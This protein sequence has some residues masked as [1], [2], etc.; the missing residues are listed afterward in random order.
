MSYLIFFPLSH[1]VSTYFHKFA[2]WKKQEEV[3]EVL[4]MGQVINDIVKQL[5]L[6]DVLIKLNVIP[7]DSSQADTQT[8]TRQMYI[9]LCW[10]HRIIKKG[11]N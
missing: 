8:N 7:L 2:F 4:N 9:S 11:V 1:T 5:K 10:L 6:R 3:E